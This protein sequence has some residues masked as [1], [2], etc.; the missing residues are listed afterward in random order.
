[1]TA[2]HQTSENENT[3][4]VVYQYITDDGFMVPRFNLNLYQ[5]AP[6]LDHDWLDQGRGELMKLINTLKGQL[7]QEIYSLIKTNMLTTQSLLNCCDKV[8]VAT[9]E[10][11][12]VLLQRRYSV[13][14]GCVVDHKREDLPVVEPDNV[15]DTIIA[16]HLI[17]DH[18]PW[19]KIHHHIK[20]LFANITRDFTNLAVLYC[21]HCNS[22]RNIKRFLRYKHYNINEKIMP[23]ERCH[24]EVF[25]P[26][27]DD[28][29]EKIEGKYSHVLYCRDYHSRFVWML[30]L[31]G[32][33]LRDLVPAV[34]TLLC[35]MIRIPIFIETATL[36]RQ[37][38]FDLLEHIAKKYKL[39]IGLGINSGTDFQRNGVTRA[40]SLFAEYKDECKD[41]W[42]ICL[43]LIIN[44]LNQVYSDRARGIPSDLLCNQVSNIAQRF[45][46]KQRKIIDELF[47]DNVVQ[48]K[49]GGGMIYLE[50][51]NS[52]PID[53]NMESENE[54][55]SSSATVGRIDYTLQEKRK[56]HEADAKADN[57]ATRESIKKRNKNNDENKAASPTEQY[58]DLTLSS[59]PR[60][61]IN[62][63]NYEASQLQ[64]PGSS[65]LKNVSVEREL[66]HDESLVDL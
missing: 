66:K 1:M 60:E 13:E 24:I 7:T 48:F 45:K 15:F 65:F 40:K 20:K 36:D 16:A 52:I 23:L 10:N 11:K 3:S 37:D 31:E 35:T 33:T 64:G 53:D 2:T 56:F 32:I 12:Y 8:T 55:S 58:D 43:R 5:L 34:T 18:L 59:P 51:Q 54:A 30:P 42:N 49:E 47:A 22:D 4:A 62:G 6:Y 50:T 19:R 21:S 61:T 29:T 46:L 26:F 63:V 39:K 28:G 27:N 57:E 25:A 38:M 17:N 14:N 9:V 44:R 41:D